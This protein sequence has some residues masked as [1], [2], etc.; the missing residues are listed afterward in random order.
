MRERRYVV[1]LAAVLVWNS[2]PDAVHAIEGEP[3]PGLQLRWDN[4]VRYSTAV[5]VSGRSETLLA[6]V[7]GDDGDRNFAPGF[8]SHRLDLLS[9][10]DLTYR[11]TVG[12]R[13]SGAGWYDIMYISVPHDRFP[14]ATR[15]LHGRKLDLLDAMVFVNGALGGVQGT[16]RAG[17]HTLLWGESLLI[18]DNGIS[19]AQAP[20]DAV[21]GLSV[22]GSQAKELFLPVG[23]VSLQIQPTSLLTLAGYVQLEHRRTRL[24]GVG[25]YFSTTDVLDAGGERLFAG[26][27]ALFRGRDLSATDLGQWG[28]S[29]RHR[30]EPLDTEVGLYFINFH[31]KV[32]QLYLLPGLAPDPAIG[33]I[34]EYVLVFPRDIKVVGASFATAFEALSLS[35]EAHVRHGTPLA[36]RP[37]M[38]MPGSP[39]DNDD[40]PLYAVGTTLHAQVNGVYSFGPSFLWRSAL[41]LAEVGWQS[42]LDIS[43]N[44]EA[45][46]PNRRR[47]AVGMQAVFS[48][49]YFQVLPNLDI[50][51]PTSLTYN[52]AGRGPFAG[53]NGGANNGGVVSV[54]LTGE[55]RRVWLATLRATFYFGRQ[56]F[57]LRRDRH[58]VSFVA[59]RTF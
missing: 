59:Q 53:F 35:G 36:S 24:P 37:Q 45:F 43:E 8:I 38:V 15:D 28:A 22:P 46:D 23:Q 2:Q 1:W 56:D 50:S 52:P 13:L 42:Y 25:S 34:G 29:A 47:H 44:R 51:V 20:L 26:G 7:N 31:E 54:G 32:P 12:L 30:I 9:E 17:R 11:E 21:K 18:A 58:F 27:G 16:L 6:N 49:T 10:L 57:Q 3:L 39:A 4:T 5:R 40:N 41:L 33:K 55:Y 14:D 19:Y 48:P